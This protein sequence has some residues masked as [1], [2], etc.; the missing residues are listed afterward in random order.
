MDLLSRL[1]SLIPVTGR[2]ELRCLFGAP[3]KIDQAVSGVREIPYHVLLSGE[4]I[5][6]DINGPPERL[7]AGDIIL[8]PA[9][10]AHYIHD[11][12]G[13][14][15][16]PE[17][18]RPKASLIVYE[19]EGAG[20]T[21]D[22]LCGRFLLGA[23][24]DRLLRDHLPGR[25]VVHSALPKPEADAEAPARTV[26][27]TRLHRLIQLMY[28]E[29]NDP[30]PGSEMFVNHLSAALF[31]L[32]LRFA[33]EGTQPPH[34]LLALSRKPRLQPAIDVMFEAPGEPWTL[35][36]LSARCHMSRAT[37]IRQ[38]Q[39]AIGRS[40]ADVLTEVRMTLAGRM[41]LN[42]E[43]PVAEIGESV[44]YQSMAAFQ[45]VFKRQIGVSPARWRASGGNLQRG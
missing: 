20:E 24:P 8:F 1:L 35:D 16:G 31:A 41:L 22:F 3:W 11:G 37:F 17:T 38:F 10:N 18:R 19:N 36:Q 39:E 44:G 25:L 45:R 28:E 13:T 34:G 12:S 21:V 5:L 43:T 26:A 42:T 29:A 32:T 2:L 33:T 4:A 14:T 15:A 30:G 7:T 23:V 9:G 40:A 6:E 27:R